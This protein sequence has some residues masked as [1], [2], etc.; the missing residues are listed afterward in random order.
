MVRFEAKDL[1]T[2]SPV[3]KEHVASGMTLAEICE[4]AITQSDNTA[5]N[6]LLREIGGPE[7]LTGFFRSIGDTVS[8]LDRWEVALNEGV[9]GDPRD[10][11]SPAAML[12]NL[13]R[14]ILGDELSASSRK[15]LIDWMVGNKTGN[16]RLR[17]G[18]PRDWRV[19]DKTGTGERGTA[20]DIGVFWPPGRKPILVTTYVTGAQVSMEQCNAAIAKVARAVAE[21]TTAQA[22]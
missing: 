3:T 21:A 12:R 18:V 2:Y 11:T 15:A 14:V 13:Q 1:V 9:P 6:M 20:N 4:A 10:T 22:G 17:A 16:A 19:A 7:G 5:G 8:R